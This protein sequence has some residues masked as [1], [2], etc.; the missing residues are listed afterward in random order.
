MHMEYLFSKGYIFVLISNLNPYSQGRAGTTSMGVKG[1]MLDRRDLNP[2]RW[3]SG[4]ILIH[5]ATTATSQRL[6]IYAIHFLHRWY[7]K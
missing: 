7:L 5:Y 1:M 2:G 4:L 6:K 3:R